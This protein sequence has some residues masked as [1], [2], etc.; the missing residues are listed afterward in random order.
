MATA[1]KPT[2]TV[3]R[4]DLVR[5]FSKQQTG[6]SAAERRIGSDALEELIDLR[7]GLFDQWWL[8]NEYRY[9]KLRETERRRGR[10]GARAFVINV[11]TG[12]IRL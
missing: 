11:Q 6:L 2:A 3:T 5:A 1:T 12:R 8:Q 4:D 9:R 10:M 7:V